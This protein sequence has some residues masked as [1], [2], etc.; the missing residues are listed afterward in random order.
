MRA[1]EFIIEV[2][3][4]RRAA[5]GYLGAAG[6]AAAGVKAKAADWQNVRQSP[7]FTTVWIPRMRELLRRSQAALSRLFAVSD[8]A[9]KT[10]LADTEIKLFNDTEPGNAAFVNPQDKVI[11]LDV[12][13]MWDAP[14]EVLLWVIAH[15]MGHIRFQ[16]RDRINPDGQSMSI[17]NMLD[18][19]Q[20]EMEADRF[21]T[22]LCLKL[23]VKQSKALTFLKQ[24]DNNSVIG[25]HPAYNRRVR[26]AQQ[27]G[28]QLSR[29]DKQQLAH[30]IR[31]LT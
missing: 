24:K 30:Y 11:T 10:I 6:L 21:G 18:S 26:Q 22:A 15:E 25:T 7:D 5:L 20:E 12:S 17:G 8:P 14:D 9:S 2:D 28:F 27:Q 3:M 23:G 31:A 29:G 16:H 13:I 4:S 19:Q 1:H